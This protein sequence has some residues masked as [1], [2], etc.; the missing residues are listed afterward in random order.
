MRRAR[1]GVT[2][3][4]LSK[5]RARQGR[6]LPRPHLPPPAARPPLLPLHSDTT[7][8]HLRSP[9][10]PHLRGIRLGGEV[11]DHVPVFLVGAVSVH[12]VGRLEGLRAV[13]D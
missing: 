10:L 1:K 7:P 8:R 4:R 3:T 12:G 2:D 5:I 13:H 11:S 9:L 6:T